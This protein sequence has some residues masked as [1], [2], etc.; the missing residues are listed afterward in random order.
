MNIPLITLP[1]LWTAVCLLVAF[2]PSKR[3]GYGADIQRLVEV[4]LSAISALI[5]WIVYLAL[6]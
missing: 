5:G 3:N 2:W 6:K 4:L 1:I